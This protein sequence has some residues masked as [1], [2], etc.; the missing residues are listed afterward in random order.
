[1]TVRR[2][3]KREPRAAPTLTYENFRTGLTFAEVRRLLWSPDPDPRTWRCKSRRAV[4]GAWHELKLQLW[5]RL[6]GEIYRK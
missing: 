3:R 2:A 4:L 6:Q 1:M 5:A